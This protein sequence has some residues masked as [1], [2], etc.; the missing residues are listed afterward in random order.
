M[1]SSEQVRNAP[2]LSYVER[3]RT[4]DVACYNV[5]THC[6]RDSRSMC[7]SNVTS[8]TGYVAAPGA[9][10]LE[11]TSHCG[12]GRLGVRRWF[13]ARTEGAIPSSG[14]SARCASSWAVLSSTRSTKRSWSIRRVAS[15]RPMSR[16]ARYEPPMQYE[17]DRYSYEPAGHGNRR[18][19][20]RRTTRR[21]RD[22]GRRWPDD[23]HQSECQLE[24]RDRRRGLDA[25]PG[26]VRRRH[27]RSRR[28]LHSR[29][30]HCRGTIA[31]GTVTVSGRYN[32]TLN[33]NTASG[34]PADR[35]GSRRNLRARAGR[36]SGRDHQW[37]SQDDCN[38]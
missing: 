2:T 35:P 24:G 23:G 32:G 30:C 36:P 13:F 1:A 12:F 26:Q 20:R 9:V 17:R 21:S 33:C 37:Q 22:P 16:R 15:R 34:S 29:R 31:A 5:R 6:M 10:E 38:R 11:Q 27:S 7:R 19:R 4:Y 18:D 3:Y 8:R 25:H 28:S 14:K